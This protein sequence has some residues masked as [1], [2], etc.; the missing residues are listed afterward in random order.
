M[1]AFERR[2][3]YILKPMLT[4]MILSDEKNTMM[5]LAASESG[6]FDVEITFSSLFISFELKSIHRQSFVTDVGK[7]LPLHNQSHSLF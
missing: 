4:L 6:S 3:T 1:G 5:T 2:A 7:R